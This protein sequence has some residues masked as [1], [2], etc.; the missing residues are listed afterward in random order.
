MTLDALSW[1]EWLLRGGAGT[2]CFLGL[3][4]L[5]RKRWGKRDDHRGEADIGLD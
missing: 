4:L 2:V 5:S 3:L 1:A